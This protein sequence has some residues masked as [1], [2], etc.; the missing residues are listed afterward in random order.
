MVSDNTA[1]NIAVGVL[2]PFAILGGCFLYKKMPKWGEHT[3]GA[4]RRRKA[5]AAASAGGGA[6]GVGGSGANTSGGS[7]AG[8]SSAAQPSPAYGMAGSDM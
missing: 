1:N 5:A 7:G 3:P 2:L 8:T 6:G 4:R